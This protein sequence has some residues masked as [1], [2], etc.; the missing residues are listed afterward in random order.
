METRLIIA[1]TLIAI[2]IALAIFGGIKLSQMKSRGQRR[3]S[4]NG[5]H[6]RAD[7]DQNK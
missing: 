7:R 5:E 2:M 4:G 6:M 3:D 1:Y